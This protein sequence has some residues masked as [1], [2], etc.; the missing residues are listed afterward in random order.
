MPLELAVL[1]TTI[2]DA[3]RA[4]ELS[5]A[6]LDAKLAACVQVKSILSYYTWEGEFCENNE[7]LL[8]MKHRRE[9]YLALAAFVRERHSYK[10]PQI[11]RVDVDAVDDDYL[12]WVFES[13]QR[14]AKLSI[15]E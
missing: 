12:A 1:V 2:D 6:V 14:D 15:E 5:R 8:Q 9:D 10:V 4:K 7:Y 11:L 3:G 13:T